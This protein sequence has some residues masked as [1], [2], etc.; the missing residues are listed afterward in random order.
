MQ[1]RAAADFTIFWALMANS[2]FAAFWLTIRILASPGLVADVLKETAPFVK[3]DQSHNSSFGIQEA[4][5]LKIDHKGLATSCPLL[6]SCYIESL[7]LDSAAWSVKKIA[8]DFTL[9]EKQEDF[10]GAHVG[11]EPQ[12]YLFKAGTYIE[13]PSGLHMTDPKYFSEPDKFIPDRHIKKG[14]NGDK[15][16][17]WGSVRP[18]GGGKSMCKGRLFAEREI[19]TLAVALFTLWEFEPVDKDGWKVPGHIR[20]VGVFKAD[21]DVRVRISRRKVE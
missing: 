11:A 16:V 4:P 10:V 20:S 9:T 3:V 21:R 5:R 19:I 14:E 15:I 17:D 12:T 13:V 7:R 6:K 2:N 18:Y 1:V 8:Q